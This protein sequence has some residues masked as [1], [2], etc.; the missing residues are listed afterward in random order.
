MAASV[1]T[2]TLETAEA[3]LMHTIFLRSTS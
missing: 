1:L 2:T 3:E